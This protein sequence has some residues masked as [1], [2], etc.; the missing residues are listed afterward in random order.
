MKPNAE[1]RYEHRKS[2]EWIEESA[3]HLF[4]EAPPL[5]PGM[6]EARPQNDLCLDMSAP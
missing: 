3:I 1:L 2:W 6:L 5:A 4:S